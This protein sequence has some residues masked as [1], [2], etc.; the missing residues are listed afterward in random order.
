[1]HLELKEGVRPFHTR[2]YPIPH[3]LYQTLK[4]EVD[5]LVKI[6]VLKREKDSEYASPSMAIRISNGT[7]KL[8]SDF[9]GVNKIIKRMPWL[10]PKISTILQ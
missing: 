5:M 8:V 7:I 2:A 1:M 6:G 4:K 3:I 9:R 10:L